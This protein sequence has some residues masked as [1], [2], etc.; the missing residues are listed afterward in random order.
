MKQQQEQQQRPGRD[1][2]RADTR[3]TRRAKQGG[4]TTIEIMIGI[5]VVAVFLIT[6]Q[7]V[8]NLLSSY[9]QDKAVAHDTQIVADAANNWLNANAATVIAQATPT[10][11]VPLSTFASYLPSTFTQTTNTFQQGYS[12]RV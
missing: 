12:L 2:R 6:A 4:W 7:T 8:L 1:V 11:I 3:S 9:Y 10:A 5:A